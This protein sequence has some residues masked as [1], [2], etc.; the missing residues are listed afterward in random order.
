MLVLALAGL[1][2]LLLSA[3]SRYSMFDVEATA[4]LSALEA[5]PVTSP[6]K[7]V[8]S[9]P[10]ELLKVRLLPVF[11]GWLPVALPEYTTKQVVSLLSSHR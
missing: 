6:V 2:P 11:N 4:T 3:P 8:G 9:I 10:V 1:L 7:S 5:V